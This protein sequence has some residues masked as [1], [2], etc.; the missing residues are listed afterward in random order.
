MVPSPTRPFCR[1]PTG[2]PIHHQAAAWDGTGHQWDPTTRTGFVLS[3]LSLPWGYMRL[4]RSTWGFRRRNNP[5]SYFWIP[6]LP[7]AAM[8]WDSPHTSL[9]PTYGRWDLLRQ[10]PVLTASSKGAKTISTM[11][12]DTHL[13][14]QCPQNHR[15]QQAQ[16]ESGSALGWC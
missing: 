7:L 4:W 11:P 2:I 12:T 16:E 10:P 8:I 5:K 13:V 6:S 1:P 15:A 14:W 3:S 9:L